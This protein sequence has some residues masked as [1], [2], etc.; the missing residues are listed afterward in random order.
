MEPAVSTAVDL[1]RNL[2]EMW[3]SVAGAWREHADFIDSRAAEVTAA[4]LDGVHPLVGERVLELA[5]GTGGTGLAAAPLVAPGEVVVSDVAEPMTVIAADRAGALGL[6]NVRARV[7]DL[8][9][10]DEPD[11][12]Y[13]IVLCREGLMF[14]VDP[15]RALAEIR[16]V[17]RPGGRLA[18]AVWGPRA[19]NPWLALVFDAVGAVLGAPIPPPGVPGPFSLD[20]T[21]RVADLLTGA[22]LVDI[23][24]G[25][26]AVPLQA[27]DFDTWWRRTAALAGPIAGR[28]AHLPDPVR[29][30]LRNRLTQAALPY[31][32]G[33]AL[34]FPGLSTI[35]TARAA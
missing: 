4:L 6:T 13:D 35:A 9:A 34:H 22:G 10:I 15:A 20:S 33:D 2:H 1:R 27:P 18:L 3:S 26:I 23:S 21:Q 11:A 5:C 31:R 32:T 12:S 7:L 19:E 25:S 8:E 17:L 16:R 30:D 29:A 28:L 24:V 14:A